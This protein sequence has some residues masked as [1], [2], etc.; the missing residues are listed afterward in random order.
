M[1]SEI[2]RVIL[3][4]LARC[5]RNYKN[6]S[7]EL[8]I[9]PGE[10]T[11]PQTSTQIPHCLVPWLPLMKPSCYREK[12]TKLHTCQR[13][14]ALSLRDSMMYKKTVQKNTISCSLLEETVQNIHLL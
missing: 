14:Y 10:D 5:S 4:R 6:A 11:I 7:A 13:K 2:K 3:I 9:P 8:I 12:A 1:L